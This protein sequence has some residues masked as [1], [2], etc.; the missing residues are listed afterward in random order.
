MAIASP[1]AGGAGTTAPGKIPAARY[2]RERP[3]M[4]P[5]DEF[6]KVPPPPERLP[7]DWAYWTRFGV[8]VLVFLLFVGWGVLTVLDRSEAIWSN[9]GYLDQRA[10]R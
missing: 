5:L 4:V 3:R 1:P 9:A 7:I 10:Q 2:K 6:G 8:I